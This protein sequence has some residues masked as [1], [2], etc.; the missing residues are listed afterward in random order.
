MSIVIVGVDPGSLFMGFGAVAVDGDRVTHLEHSV[1]SAPASWDFASRLA[2]IHDGLSEALVRTRPNTV[3][4][5]DIFL[6]RNVDSAFKLGHVRGVC[7]LAA[8]TVKAEVVEYAARSVKKG[9]CGNGAAS[10]EEVQLILFAALG[11]RGPAQV[12][13]SDA[14]ALAFYHARKLEVA[15]HMRRGFEGANR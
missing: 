14:L 6:G 11:V 15:G 7:L 3:V 5:E 8:R 4:I 13:A 2:R 9:I 1:I 10:K 12:D